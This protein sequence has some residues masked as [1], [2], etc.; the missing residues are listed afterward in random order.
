MKHTSYETVEK[1]LAPFKLLDETKNGKIFFVEFLKKDGSVRRMTA[2]RSV[3]KGVT[4]KGMSYNP[5]SRG[6]L[7][8][9]DMDKGQFRQINLLKVRKFC[10]NGGKYL[11]V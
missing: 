11:A 4:G 10:A 8:V 5:L 2:R 3:T 1:D 6:L 7:T 9:F